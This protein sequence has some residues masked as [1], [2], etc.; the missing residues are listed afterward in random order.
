M[1]RMR[2]YRTKTEDIPLEFL[3]VQE[4]N[5]QAD[6]QGIQRKPSIPRA[7]FCEHVKRLHQ[8]KN[9]GFTMEFRVRQILLIMSHPK[10]IIGVIKSI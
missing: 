2:S 5:V 10:T 9:Q 8:E 3:N 1:K 6:E 7:Q 4:V